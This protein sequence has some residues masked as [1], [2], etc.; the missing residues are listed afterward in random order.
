MQ[1]PGNAT[2]GVLIIDGEAGGDRVA[3]CGSGSL[4][5]AQVQA[6]PIRGRRSTCVYS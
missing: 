5:T 2:L 1:T 3:A 4:V 6:R